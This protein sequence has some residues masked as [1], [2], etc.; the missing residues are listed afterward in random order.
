[1]NGI[2]I[3]IENNLIHWAW[4]INL[5]GSFL[6]NDIMKCVNLIFAI[7]IF[8]LTIR[9]ASVVHNDKLLP[10]NLTNNQ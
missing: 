7:Y 2:L 1:M 8:L 5:E 4:R 6:R 10:N 9:K 3:K